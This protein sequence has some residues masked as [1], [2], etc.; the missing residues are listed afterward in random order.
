MKQRSEKRMRQHEYGL[1][2]M[3]TFWLANMKGT[4][5]SGDLGTGEGV[6][7]N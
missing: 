1:Q 5:Q 3:Y 2:E 6:I 7:S 4:E